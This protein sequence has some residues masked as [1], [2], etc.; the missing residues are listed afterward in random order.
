MGDD[1]IRNRL[2]QTK[3]TKRKEIWTRQNLTLSGSNTGQD[4]DKITTGIN[5]TLYKRKMSAPAGTKKVL[6][7]SAVESKDRFTE[8]GSDTDSLTIKGNNCYSGLTKF[9]TPNIVVVKRN[10]E[11]SH[12]SSEK[13]LQKSCSNSNLNMLQ[14]ALCTLSFD[15]PSVYIHHVVSHSKTSI[16]YKQNPESVNKRKSFFVCRLCDKKFANR[17]FARGHISHFLQN[18]DHAHEQLSNFLTKEFEDFADNFIFPVSIGSLKNITVDSKINKP[19]IYYC[20][21]CET[22]FNSKSDLL[23]HVKNCIK[24]KLK[25]NCSKCDIYFETND[26]LEQHIQDGHS[27]SETLQIPELVFIKTEDISTDEKISMT[28]YKCPKCNEVCNSL[29]Q[30]IQHRDSIHYKKVEIQDT[31]YVCAHCLSPF[32]SQAL[33]YKHIQIH[34]RE[35]SGKPLKEKNKTSK[36]FDKI[37]YQ[38]SNGKW[39]CEVCKKSFSSKRNI[40]RHMTLHDDEEKKDH[41]CPFCQRIF[42]FK[43]YLHY[44]IMYMHGMGRKDRKYSKATCARLSSV[45]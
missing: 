9:E 43:R 12:D 17:D 23:G 31:D 30:L 44:H 19:V 21:K 4:T 32:P 6:K 38:E 10:I 1:N 35:L 3:Q 29:Q 40:L 42:H 16:D 8:N 11:D 14:C 2:S 13:Q 36:Y 33:L 37:V 7:S 15:N 20:A 28:N 18:P 34:D 22:N 5:L 26:L 25:F 24:N 45:V 39:R 41:T 27:E